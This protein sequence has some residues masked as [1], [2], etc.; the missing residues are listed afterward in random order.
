MQIN[1]KQGWN[2]YSNMA[3]Q[4]LTVLSAEENETESIKATMAL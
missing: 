3:N 1:S 2:T 4:I